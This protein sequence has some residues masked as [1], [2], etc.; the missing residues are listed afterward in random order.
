MCIVR[1]LVDAQVAHAFFDE[2]VVGIVEE[3][4]VVRVS[5]TEEETAFPAVMSARTEGEV[6]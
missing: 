1:L 3:C 4:F 5:G 6:G 2:V